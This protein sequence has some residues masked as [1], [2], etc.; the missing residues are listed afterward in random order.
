MPRWIKIVVAIGLLGALYWR[1]DA[2]KVALALTRLDAGYLALALLMFIPQTIVSAWRWQWLAATQCWI[3]LP[4]AMR[5]TLAASAWNLAAPSKL[6]DFSKA[7]MLPLAAGLRRRAWMLVVVEKICDVTALAWLWLLAATWQSA[8]IWLL[9]ALIAGTMF[10]VVKI[11]PL[12]P[13]PAATRNSQPA[14]QSVSVF[15]WFLHLLQIH[16]MVLAAGIEVELGTTLA[17]V[18]AAIF[19]GLLPVSLWGIGPRDGAL[20]WLF[21]DV[22]PASVLA[23]VGLLTAMRY[24]VPGAVGIP[25]VWKNHASKQGQRFAIR[26]KTAVSEPAMPY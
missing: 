4:E 21:S 18:P 5:Q 25:L 6:G 12:L 19:A 2:S 15:L 14:I 1:C 8:N 26:P 9:A 20:I 3:S 7:A 13:F 22:A 10:G 17:R 11:M 24:L 23:A 16:L